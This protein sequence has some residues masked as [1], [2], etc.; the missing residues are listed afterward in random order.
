MVDMQAPVRVVDDSYM[1]EV[2]EDN[3]VQG[4]Y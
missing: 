2:E 1:M 3:V 4:A